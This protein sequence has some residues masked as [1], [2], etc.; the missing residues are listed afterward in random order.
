VTGKTSRHQVRARER[1]PARRFVYW[2][3][4]ERITTRGAIM[5]ELLFDKIWN[6][7]VV[8]EE[9]GQPTLLYID[10]HLIHEITTAQAFEGLRLSGRRVRRPDL[11]LATVDHNVPTD[12]GRDHLPIRDEIA[13]KQIDTL[14][15]NCREFGI[16]LEGMGSSEQGIVHVIGPEQ[17]FSLPGMT[18]TCGDSHTATHGAVGALAFGIGTSEVEHV[19]ATQ[20]LP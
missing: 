8:R 3:S 4:A 15:R 2:L 18:I 16:K 1:Q 19:L 14:I 6:S 13:R 20:T 10:L 7:H 11:T 12:R 9:P 5:P 17:G